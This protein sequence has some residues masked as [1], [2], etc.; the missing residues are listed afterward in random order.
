MQQ[1]QVTECLMPAP[2]SF[3]PPSPCITIDAVF[4]TWGSVTENVLVPASA[5]T[6]EVDAG[7][8][9]Y[10]DQLTETIVM[11]DGSAQTLSQTSM[12]MGSFVNIVFP[13]PT[14]TSC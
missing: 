2:S 10:A 8:T 1:D 4:N 13:I 3:H 14:C 7:T 12:D 5:F 6:P 11:P 9:Q